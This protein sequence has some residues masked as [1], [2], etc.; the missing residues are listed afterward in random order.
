MRLGLEGQV[1]FVSGSSLGMGR[2][3]ARELYA[4]GAY[5]MIS[6]RRAPLLIEAKAWIEASGSP[7]GGKVAYVVGDMTKE[8]DVKNAIEE[9]V[10]VF[11]ESPSVVVA[12][13]IP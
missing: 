1:A 9:C 10:K 5:V 4:E 12:N 7:E 2:E 11:G 3:V 6:A 13:V 8:E